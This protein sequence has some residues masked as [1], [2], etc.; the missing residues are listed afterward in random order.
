MTSAV[1]VRGLSKTYGRTQ[2]VRGLDLDVEYGEIFAILGPNG[3]G[4]STT[5]EILEGNRRR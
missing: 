4:K 3:A 2:A 1:H 5:I